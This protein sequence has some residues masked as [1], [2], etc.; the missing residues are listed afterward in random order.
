MVAFSQ[1]GGPARATGPEIQLKLLIRQGK[2][3]FV[4]R[5]TITAMHQLTVFAGATVNAVDW[6]LQASIEERP[7][8]PPVNCIATD[9]E[10]MGATICIRRSLP[11]WISLASLDA[12]KITKMPIGSDLVE[13]NRS[14]SRGV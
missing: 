12:C 11:V 5:L 9:E 6:R 4:T 1:M 14:K 2:M 7:G 13:H 3:S 8:S 10:M